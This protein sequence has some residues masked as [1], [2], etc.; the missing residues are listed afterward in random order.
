MQVLHERNEINNRES[1][2]WLVVS[3]SVFEPGALEITYWAFPL[4]RANRFDV[5]IAPRSR[6][7]HF[8]QTTL[9]SRPR[10]CSDNT[11]SVIHWSNCKN[12]RAKLL[13]IN[14]VTIVTYWL[15][16]TKDGNCVH[17]SETFLRRTPLS[18]TR[19]IDH[20]L[21]TTSKSGMHNSPAVDACQYQQTAHQHH[22]TKLANC[23]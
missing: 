23:T 14:R 20:G 10:N 17:K 22:F 6:S 19:S 18:S 7:L 2:S 12:A 1:P 15:R 13:F 16:R 21:P 8:V 4:H 3:R 5:S 9:Q 11:K